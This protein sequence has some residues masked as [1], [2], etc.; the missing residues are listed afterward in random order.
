MTE[1]QEKP[2][3]GQARKSQA[4]SSLRNPAAGGQTLAGGVVSFWEKFGYT[5]TASAAFTGLG[6]RLRLAGGAG[7]DLS[8]H[9]EE[10]RPA[11]V[12]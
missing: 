9:N 6:V 12:L 8:W 7:F 1:I 11:F 3:A 4:R 2:P 5:P 10:K